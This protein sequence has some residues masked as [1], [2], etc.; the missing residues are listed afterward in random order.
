MSIVLLLNR[1]N[2]ET[3][4]AASCRSR[5]LSPA[6]GDSTYPVVLL[7]FTAASHMAPAEIPI[8]KLKQCVTVGTFLL[9]PCLESMCQ[10]QE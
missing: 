3:L 5:A 2:V 10:L 4:S 7:V 9:E 6:A 8:I 1:C